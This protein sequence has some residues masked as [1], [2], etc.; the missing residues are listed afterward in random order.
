VVAQLVDEAGIVIDI[1]TFHIFGCND[2]FLGGAVALYNVSEPS[3]SAM[4]DHGLG[5][6]V[7]RDAENVRML[8]DILEDLIPKVEEQNRREENAFEAIKR[9]ME[10]DMEGRAEIPDTLKFV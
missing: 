9:A 3:N 8:G 2:A 6:I 4:F 7:P 5:H 10:R 1:P